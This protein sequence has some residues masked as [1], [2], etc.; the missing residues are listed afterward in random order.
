MQKT[1]S[2]V[3]GDDATIVICIQQPQFDAITRFL[4][5]SR[6][7]NTTVAELTS[8]F[9]RMLL[10]LAAVLSRTSIFHSDLKPIPSAHD[11][12]SRSFVQAIEC[13]A[14]A[15]DV[16]TAVPEVIIRLARRVCGEIHDETR[17]HYTDAVCVARCTLR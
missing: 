6:I 2:N 1:F 9:D 10:W 17:T 4:K 14:A 12:F 11:S 15:A 7:W 13:A 8:L 16:Q 3:R 5:A